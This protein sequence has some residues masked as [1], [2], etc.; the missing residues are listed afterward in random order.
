MKEIIKKKKIFFSWWK[1]EIFSLESQYIHKYSL[2][3]HDNHRV[4][5][6]IYVYIHIQPSNINL[7]YSEGQIVFIIV[8][9]T[10]WPVVWILAPFFIYLF[11]NKL[12]DTKIKPKIHHGFCFSITTKNQ[13]TKNW[14][15]GVFGFKLNFFLHQLNNNFKAWKNVVSKNW[16]LNHYNWASITPYISE[17]VP[18]YVMLLRRRPVDAPSFR[19]TLRG[20]AWSLF[21]RLLQSRW[22]FSPFPR[23]IVFF[24]AG[25]IPNIWAGQMFC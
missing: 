18:V 8:P 25:N 16:A 12:T 24:F 13:K 2:F 15:T 4:Q 11:F 14:V 23:A 1:C 10:N 17:Y 3:F 5:L 7:S 9:W 22:L 6:C 19:D 20:R 21:S